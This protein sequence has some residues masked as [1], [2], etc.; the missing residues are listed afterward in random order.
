MKFSELNVININVL[1]DL[2][3]FL[4]VGQRQTKQSQIKRLKSRS[5]IKVFTVCLR[6]V[7]SKFEKKEYEV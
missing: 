5:L 7:L 4:F 6:I 3:H 2:A 1:H